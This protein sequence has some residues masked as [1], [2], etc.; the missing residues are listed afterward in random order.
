MGKEEERPSTEQ[1]CSKTLENQMIHDTQD[2]VFRGVNV[3]QGLEQVSVRQ[4]GDHQTAEV[5]ASGR[6]ESKKRHIVPWDAKETHK[7]QMLPC[8]KD[9]LFTINPIPDTEFRKQKLYPLVDKQEI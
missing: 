4:V 8:P 6:S 2:E 5:F 9:E 1:K 3:G 7:V